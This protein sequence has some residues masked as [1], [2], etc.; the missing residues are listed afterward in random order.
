MP[1]HEKNRTTQKRWAV[2]TPLASLTRV[3]LIYGQCNREVVERSPEPEAASIQSIC[4]ARPRLAAPTSSC[5][6]PQATSPLF[7][8]WTTSYLGELLTRGRIRTKSA[9][10]IVP[11]S[12]YC[13]T[14]QCRFSLPLHGRLVQE[15]SQSSRVYTKGT[16]Y[17]KAT[18]TRL[19]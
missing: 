7:I 18:L 10:S 8:P 19:C 17:P 9:S 13:I 11:T 1:N 12:T 4:P 3:P 15:S 6:I 2:S 16:E 14:F 5:G